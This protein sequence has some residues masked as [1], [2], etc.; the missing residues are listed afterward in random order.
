[1]RRIRKVRA[2]TFGK[3]RPF[4]RYSLVQR[5]TIGLCATVLQNETKA[6]QKILRKRARVLPLAAIA[7]LPLQMA[8]GTDQK[9]EKSKVHIETGKRVRVVRFVLLALIIT[10]AF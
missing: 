5:I 1:M 8:N 6:K 2:K 9:G 7:A 10:Y 4:Q 3:R